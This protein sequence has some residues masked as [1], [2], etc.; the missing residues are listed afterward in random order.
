MVKKKYRK[1]EGRVNIYTST[2]SRIHT[3]IHTCIRSLN[4][5]NGFFLMCS[6]TLIT[7]TCLCN[8]TYYSF[9]LYVLNSYKAKYILITWML[10]YKK[11]CFCISFAILCVCICMYNLYTNT[12]ERMQ[13]TIN[14]LL[15]LMET[16]ANICLS[17]EV[18]LKNTFFEN[19]SSTVFVI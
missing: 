16:R 19:G 14:Y 2:I 5:L 4:Q 8:R 9:S 15:K 18:F 10:L 17:Y 12:N 11:H 6:T 1:T 7:C 3:Y 13:T